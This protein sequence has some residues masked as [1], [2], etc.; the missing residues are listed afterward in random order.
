VEHLCKA[1]EDRWHYPFFDRRPES[2]PKG[3]RFPKLIIQAAKQCD[4]LIVVVSNEYFMSKWPM[5]ELN[6]FVKAHELNHKAKCPQGGPKIL[7]LFYG[8]SIKDLEDEALQKKWFENWEKLAKDDPKKRIVVSDWKYALD[9]L[10]S[11][12]GLEYNKQLKEIV[13]YEDEIVSH[14]CK[15]IV[16]DLKW[17]DSHVQGKSNICKVISIGTSTSIALLIFPIVAFVD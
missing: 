4:M 14:V 1:L 3:E 5:I 9:V 16:P 8:L 6:A 7:P 11:F 10:R 17:D 2:L 13:A 12:N 15:S